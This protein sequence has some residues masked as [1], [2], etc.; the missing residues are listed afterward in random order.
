MNKPVILSPQAKDPGTSA[1]NT[2]F[3]TSPEVIVIKTYK[4]LFSNNHYNRAVYKIT[5]LR[6][7]FRMTVTLRA[8]LGM[9]KI[10]NLYIRQI[11]KNSHN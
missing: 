10:T 2:G 5:K 8:S 6:A 3:F 11:R 9:T 1:L 7:G 4:L